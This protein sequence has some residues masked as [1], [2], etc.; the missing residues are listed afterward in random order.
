MDV[1][2][3]GINMVVLENKENIN[4]EEIKLVKQ[5]LDTEARKQLFQKLEKA[6]A[7]TEKLCHKNG[8]E[9]KDENDVYGAGYLQ[10]M[11]ECLKEFNNALVGAEINVIVKFIED[12][13]EKYLE[14]K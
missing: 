6:K 7:D 10:T 4:D 3:R 8:A 5:S 12:L 9:C 1:L 2:N 13:Y 11:G 14:M